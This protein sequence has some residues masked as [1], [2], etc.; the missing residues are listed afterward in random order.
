MDYASHVIDLVNDLIAPVTKIKGVILKSF[1]SKDVEASV[2]SLL[3][4]ENN[5]SGVLSVNWSDE[6]Y[7]KMST[8]ITVIGTKGKIISDASELKVYFKAPACP[9]GLCHWMERQICN[10]FNRGSWFLFKGEEY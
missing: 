10:R 6:T 7:R 9:K 3:E 5:I 4:T 1:Y 8:S 2:Y